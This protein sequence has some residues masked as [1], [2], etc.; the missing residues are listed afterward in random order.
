M[1]A[2]SENIPSLPDLDLKTRV[3]DP[4]VPK[5]L[6]IDHKGSLQLLRPQEFGN[7]KGT[8]VAEYCQKSPKT[9]NE[10]ARRVNKIAN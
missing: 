6:H 4:S 10:K 2:R 3:K 1:N 7:I 8:I 9:T 5:N